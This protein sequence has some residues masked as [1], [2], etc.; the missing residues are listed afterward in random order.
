MAYMIAK[1]DHCTP[2]CAIP[3]IPAKH[4]NPLISLQ[5]A[6]SARL[7]GSTSMFA[8]AHVPEVV[9]SRTKYGERPKEERRLMI[10][11]C[12]GRYDTRM[13]TRIKLEKWRL[14]RRRS[15]QP[16]VRSYSETAKLVVFG[17]DKSSQCVFIT[18][19]MASHQAGNVKESGCQF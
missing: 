17:E 8:K 18:S 3:S 14:E 6:R 2:T 11:M 16:S 15:P 12:C 19:F 10:R 13:P 1:Q 7:F 9:P 4:A 5:Q